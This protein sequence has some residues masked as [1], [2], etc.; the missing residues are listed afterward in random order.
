MVELAVEVWPELERRTFSSR[1]CEVAGMGWTNWPFLV[2]ECCIFGQLAYMGPLLRWIPTSYYC[3]L[4]HT[5]VQLADHSFMWH[6]FNHLKWTWNSCL[7]QLSLPESVTSAL[8]LRFPI[9]FGTSLCGGPHSKHWTHSVFPGGGRHLWIP[10]WRTRCS[11]RLYSVLS[12]YYFT[13]FI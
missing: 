13:S 2:A 10:H 5:Q 11:P 7:Y 8:D 12:S 6:P 1:F 9:V 4:N 3:N